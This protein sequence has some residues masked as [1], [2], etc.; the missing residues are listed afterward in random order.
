MSSCQVHVL[1]LLAFELA[2]LT[3]T[4]SHCWQW[5]EGDVVVLLATLNLVSLSV[6]NI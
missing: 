4:D 1:R 3:E 5:I 6:P 2:N